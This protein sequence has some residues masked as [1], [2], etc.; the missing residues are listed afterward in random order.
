MNLTHRYLF[1]YITISMLC[2]CSDHQVPKIGL[3]LIPPTTITDKVNLEIRAGIVNEDEIPLDCEV[4]LYLNG[5]TD[6]HILCKESLLIAGG[7]SESIKYVMKTAGKTGE[8]I[9]TLVVRSGNS[10]QKISK[11]IEVV[12]SEIRSTRTIDGAWVGLYHWSEIEGKHWN[13]DIREISDDQWREVLQ[14][15]HKIGM[16]IVVIQETFSNG[17]FYVGKHDMTPETYQGKAYYPSKLYNKRI[18]IQAEDPLKAILSE[19][20]KLGMH[21]FMGIGL[22][23]WFDFTPVSLEWHKKVAKELWDIYGH[24]ESFYGFYVSEEIHGSL[25]SGESV[26]ELR[27]LR[28]EEVVVFFEEFSAYCKSFAPSKPIMLASNCYGVPSATE[29]Y[30]KLLKNLD[31]LCPFGFGRMPEG[32]L[33]AKQAAELLQDLCDKSGTHLWFDLE[34]FLFNDDM[35]LYPRDTESIINDL[36]LLDNF[37]KVLCYQFPGVFNDP[38]A[39]FRIGEEKTITL[40]RKYQEYLNKVKESRYKEENKMN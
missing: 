13:K 18:P 22:F 25:D 28:K 8:N 34:A 6:Y 36:Y 7:K 37:E 2:S 29:T 9:I 39:S 35:S 5:D 31:I 38:E 10:E 17:T 4:L 3:T 32:D 24:H 15:M 23:S 19:A 11:K 21:I 27:N 1:I 26:E 20:D 12:K 14:S 40:F 33:T 30:P 16:D